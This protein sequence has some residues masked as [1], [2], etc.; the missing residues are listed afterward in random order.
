MRLMTSD[1]KTLVLSTLQAFAL[2]I[3][4]TMLAYFIPNG[5]DFFLLLYPPL[6][7]DWLTWK[8]VS[9]VFLIFCCCHCRYLRCGRH[10]WVL[11]YTH[12]HVTQHTKYWLHF[13]CTEHEQFATVHNEFHSLSRV[14]S[15]AA[16]V[17][18][19]YTLTSAFTVAFVLAFAFT[20]IF[21]TCCCSDVLLNFISHRRHHYY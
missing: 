6:L 7:T 11:L 14:K 18:F 10:R 5:T 12:L 13:I 8:L 20:F 9:F 17:Y 3:A 1:A 16:S 15:N 21:T 4:I 2:L 19:F